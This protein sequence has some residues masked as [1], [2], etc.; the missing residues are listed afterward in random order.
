MRRE[1]EATRAAEQ[2]RLDLEL[3]TRRLQGEELEKRE[4][5]AKQKEGEAKRLADQA[6]LDAQKYHEMETQALKMKE[7]VEADAADTQRR[8]EELALREAEA[9]ER[10]EGALQRERGAR[11]REI[12]ILRREEQAKLA[13][14]L[15][16]LYL[17]QARLQGEEL[18]KRE[19]EVKEK[20]EEAKRL[21]DESKQA[22][23]DAQ[24]RESEAKNL[25]VLETQK[26]E[27]E[28]RKDADEARAREEQ[29]QKDLQQAKFYLEK[30]IQPEVWPTEEEFQLA[31]NRVQYDPEKL[32]FAV[33]GSS[34]SGK[35]SL[36]NAFR[37]LKNK[38]PQAART[39][40][41]ETTNIITRYPDPRKELPYERLV[42]FD[43]P[44]AGTL[45][46]PGWQYFN[47]QG[48]FIFDIIVLVYDAVIISI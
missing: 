7:K 5:D 33:C 46:I 43:C 10:E 16:P 24:K 18:E 40:V 27:T 1:E 31:R 21:A 41:V 48:L 26:R 35:S 15:A 44:G 28:A 2:T 23:L 19:K 47:Q 22:A 13:A 38:D 36:I 20:E 14:K 9:R 45:E 30:V 4:K 12:D 11:Q 3:A 42:W 29:V 37:G 32:H 17:E 25:R 6:A 34:G 8:V 39:G